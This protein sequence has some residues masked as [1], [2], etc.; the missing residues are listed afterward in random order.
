MWQLHGWGRAGRL[1]VGRA[2]FPAGPGFPGL[3]RPLTV[4]SWRRVKR[5]FHQNVP[6]PEPFFQPLYSVH[7][8]NFQVRGHRAGRAG[9]A[10]RPGRLRVWALGEGWGDTGTSLSASSFLGIWSGFKF[11]H[12]VS[13]G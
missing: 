11:I 4:L 8:G 6:S 12:G 7:H 10:Q 9:V 13:N 3:G 2:E 5:T 1:L